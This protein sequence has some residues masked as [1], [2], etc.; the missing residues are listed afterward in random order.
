MGI[1]NLVEKV[2]KYNANFIF[3]LKVVL[4]LVISNVS[5]SSPKNKLKNIREYY[6]LIN[7][8]ELLVIDSNYLEAKQKYINSFQL[9]CPFAK[10]IYN[11][12]LCSYYTK[13]STCALKFINNLAYHGFKK[14]YFFDSL[15]DP[16]FYKYIFKDF[17]SCYNVGFK[18]ANHKMIQ[19]I[20]SILFDDRNAR[21]SPNYLN[22][23]A[24]VDSVNIDKLISFIKCNGWPNYNKIGLWCYESNPI[25]DNFPFLLILHHNRRNTDKYDKLL[26]SEIKVGNMRSD[27][28][29]AIIFHR[30]SFIEKYFIDYNLFLNIWQMGVLNTKERSIVNVNR[31]NMYMVNLIN[32]SKKFQFQY[33]NNINWGANFQKSS[34]RFLNY[35]LIPAPDQ[36]YIFE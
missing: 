8:A 14:F 15:Y 13:D 33:I 3:F 11:A 16:I 4:L 17:D 28:F 24:K 36:F 6:R 29:A 18:N 35:F 25:M 23:I 21:L 20:D 27:H 32:Y 7:D 34:F 2:Y 5:I 1:R 30:N 31:K 12:F 26:L 10:D 19:F 9:N 22:L